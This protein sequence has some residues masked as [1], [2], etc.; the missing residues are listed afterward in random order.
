MKITK[1]RVNGKRRVTGYKVGGVW[2]TLSEAVCLA[3]AGKISG[4]YVRKYRGTE[5][6]AVATGSK[7]KLGD[8]PTVVSK[9]YMPSKRIV[10]NHHH[11]T[12][13]YVMGKTPYSRDRVVKMTKDGEIEGLRVIQR[14]RREYVV[15]ASSSKPLRSLPKVPKSKVSML[16]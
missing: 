8:L 7:Q 16:A 6:L 13:G 3:R 2:R 12:V 1:R 10:T 11:N 15:S 5:H 4:V 9:G 14:L